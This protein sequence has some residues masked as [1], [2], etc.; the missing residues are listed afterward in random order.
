MAHSTDYTTTNSKYV[1]VFILLISLIFC[2][3]IITNGQIYSIIPLLATLIAVSYGNFSRISL[4][5]EAMVFTYGYIT[6]LKIKRDYKYDKI[7]KIIENKDV[8]DCLKSIR[9][10]Y[11][12]LNGG[13]SFL[14][15]KRNYVCDFES[16]V[17]DLKNRKINIHTL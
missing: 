16:F 1:M 9:V 11:I 2:G 15:I 3:W 10:E 6:K 7:T 8:H 4:T 12:T 17:K 13:Y 14:V 5:N